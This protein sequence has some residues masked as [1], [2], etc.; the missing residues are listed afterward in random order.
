M[1]FKEIRFTKLKVVVVIRILS[2]TVQHITVYF[3]YLLKFTVLRKLFRIAGPDLFGALQ[4]RA[5]IVHDIPYL[6]GDLI[7]RV[8]KVTHRFG[9]FKHNVFVSSISNHA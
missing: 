1:M 9:T 4:K 5:K 2:N 6:A 7:W 8:S 3:I